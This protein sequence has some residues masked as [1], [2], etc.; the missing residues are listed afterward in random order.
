MAEKR[1]VDIGPLL[2]DLKNELEDLKSATE[3]LT[4]EEAAQNG[5]Q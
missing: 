2:E 1:I 5:N 4:V 3:V